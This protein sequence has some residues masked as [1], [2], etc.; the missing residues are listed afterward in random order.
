MGARV[1]FGA[2][3]ELARRGV[4]GVV[5][6]AVLIG[7]PV[8]ASAPEWAEARAAVA[9]RLVNV[10]SANDLVL[11]VL[12]RA[13]HLAAPAGLRP[14]GT[15]AS[16]GD[17]GGNEAASASSSACCCV[18]VEDVNLSAVVAGHTAYPGAVPEL[19]ALLGLTPEDE[20]AA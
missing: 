18:C 1:V 15:T 3:R 6:C 2:L 9:G 8:P 20:A 13:G 5:E 17:V 10:Y 7:A 4:R 19:L 12:Y 11:G 14:V 16:A